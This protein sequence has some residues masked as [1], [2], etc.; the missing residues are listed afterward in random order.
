MLVSAV[1]AL[2]IVVAGCGKSETGAPTPVVSVQA[3]HPQVSTIA[4][5]ISADAVLAPLAQAAISPKITAPVRN[6]YVQRG[7]HVKAGQLLATLENSDLTA[8]ALDN[9]GTYT[10]AQA[11]TTMQ[12]RRKCPKST[13]RRELDL[14]AG[15]GQSRSQ[16]KHRE[17]RKQLFAEGAIPGRDLDTAEAAL[18]QAQAA[19]DTAKQTSGIR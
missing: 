18:V 10:A 13:R 7:A 17:R 1:V 3:E 11:P 6:F 12:P 8:A 9:Q 15:Q 2:T 4:E 19:Y 14:D 5:R 16:S